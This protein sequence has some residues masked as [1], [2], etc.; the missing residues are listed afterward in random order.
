MRKVL[1]LLLL[2]FNVQSALSQSVDREFKGISE[3]EN[4]YEIHVSDGTYRLVFYSSNIVET[5]FIPNNQKYKDESHAVVMD[6]QEVKVSVTQSDSFVKLSSP[7][8]SVEIRKSPLRISYYKDDSL[9]ISEKNGFQKDSLK[10]IDF[11][12]SEEEAL[13]G[14]GARALNMKRRG[15]RL[16]LYNKAHYGYGE[17]SELLNYTMPVVLSSKQYLVHFDNAPIGYLDM[18]SQ[19]NNTLAYETITGQ[20]TYQIVSGSSWMD[21]ID[22]YTD[23]TGKQP[24]LPRWAMGNYSSRFGYHSQ[25]EVL[26]TANLFEKEHIPLDAIILDLFWFG[27][28]MKGNMGNF[29]F[30]ADSFPRPQQMISNLQHDNIE[31]ILITEP[32]VQTTSKRWDEAVEEEVLAKD[33]LGQ[34]LTFDFF[35]GNTGIIDVFDQQGYNWFKNIYKELLGMGVTGIWGDLGEPEVHPEEAVHATGTANEVHNIYGHQWAKL[36]D[37]AFHEYDSNMRPFILMRAGYSGSQRYGIIPWS[38]DVSRSWGGLQSQPEIS[39][40][41][42]MQGIGYMHSDLGGFAGANLD[43]ELYVRWMQYG[44]FQPIY[45]PHAQEAVPSEP[46]FRSDSTKALSKKAIELRNQ[47]LPYNYHL[48]Y[49]NHTTGAPLMRPL[50]FEEPE[51]ESLYHYDDAY[52]WGNDFLVAPVVKSGQIEKEV[53]FPDGSNW[54]NFYT[55]E[56]YHGGQRKTVALND[57]TIPIYVRGGA[58][59][60]MTGPVQNA[61]EYTG[62]DLILHYYADED[63][64]YSTSEMYNDDGLT[65]GAVK[66]EKYELLTF[67]GAKDQNNLNFSFRAEIGE[68]YTSSEKNIELIIH[69][70]NNRPKKVTVNGERVSINWDQKNKRVSIPIL[71][72]TKENS[73]NKNRSD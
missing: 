9:L 50:F 39:L 71:W 56:K 4:H 66:K 51:N 26:E 1:F 29:E 28:E 21:V 49:Q 62:D 22:H 16:E 18:D 35:F 5:S 72:D 67:E 42:G 23:L 45:R 33:S 41:M 53:Y 69:N 54:Y 12:I 47:L 52:L 34:P 38:G 64:N 25:K 55:D 24:M 27:K 17:K 65:R 68:K 30:H 60:P 63:V 15:H 11:N 43:D 3:K 31:T 2:V 19:A 44:V 20:M 32:Y 46:V 40:Q 36:V 37:E 59:I 61:K 8:I 13:Y 70:V 6:P 14:G 73:I 58:F 48:V 57:T 7:S 10:T